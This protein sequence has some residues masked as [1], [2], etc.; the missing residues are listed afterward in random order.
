[1]KKL[2]TTTKG[3]LE[4]LDPDKIFSYVYNNNTPTTTKKVISIIKEDKDLLNAFQTVTKN[5]LMFKT[6]DNRGKFVFEKFAD[7]MKNNKQ[8]LTETF[9]DNPQYVKDLDMFRDALEITSRKSAQKTIGKAETALNDIIR[10]RL[11]QFTVAGRTFTA[12]KKIVRS[13]IDKQLTEIIIDPARLEDLVKLKAVK[14]G[15]P[16]AKQIISR[17]FGYYIFDQQFFEDDEFTPTMID[18]IDSQRVSEAVTDVKE[19][20]DNKELAQLERPTLPLNLGTST[21]APGA[22]P[23]DTGQG[24]ASIQTRQ[25]YGS[26]FPQDVLGEAIAKRGMA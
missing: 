3:K 15:S 23:P 21:A 16:A 5:D 6:T 10:A 11:G 13:D 25:D 24:L 26:L 4:N 20:D 2:G 9:V 19:G 22:M 7:Y 18:F 8:I 17:L 14:P 12:L 1:M